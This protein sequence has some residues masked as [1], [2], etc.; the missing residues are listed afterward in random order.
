MGIIMN[1][2]TSEQE[3]VV[4]GAYSYKTSDTMQIV[5]YKAD[6]KGYMPKVT[7]TRRK[8]PSKNLLDDKLLQSLVG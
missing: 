6:R 1:P 3:L 4:I 7:F 8:K 2:G 5:T